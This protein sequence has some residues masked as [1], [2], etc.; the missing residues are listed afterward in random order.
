MEATGLKGITRKEILGNIKELFTFSYYKEGLSNWMPITK[1]AALIG[2]AIIIGT[3]IPHGFAITNIISIISG[4]IGYTCVLAITNGKRINGLL[5]FI[6]AIGIGG[7]AIHAGNPADAVMQLAY[8]LALDIPVIIFGH[9]WTNAKIKTFDKGALK[10]ILIVGV[11]G[12]AAMYAMDAFWLHTPRPV[13][14]A[15][16]A[17]IGFIGSA[18]MLGKYSTQYFFWNF[19][20][21][22]SL[23]LWGVTAMQGDANWVLFATYCMYLMNSMI[24]AFHSPWSEARKQKRLEK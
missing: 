5:G 24:G 13:L 10:I 6:S 23:T 2:F 21:I 14:D 8:L 20:G 18:L 17:T 3:G 15:F 19:Q 11:I 12:F 16:G 22:M 9:R 4:L 7:M 1:V